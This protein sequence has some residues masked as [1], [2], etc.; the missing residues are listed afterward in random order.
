MGQRNRSAADKE[1]TPRQTRSFASTSFFLD[2]RALSIRGEY[3][4]TY[5]SCDLNKE[6]ALSLALSLAR[7]V[8]IDSFRRL[9]PFRS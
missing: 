3:M 8:P 4:S 1:L 5:I 6:P 7:F 2:S 9:R